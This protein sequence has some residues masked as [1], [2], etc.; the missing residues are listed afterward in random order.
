MKNLGS[1]KYKKIAKRNTL[2][3]DAPAQVP[4]DTV[5]YRDARAMTEISDDSVALVVTSPP[6]WN[7]K[8][9]SLDGTQTQRRVRKL[10]GQVGDLADYRVYLQELE[11]IWR[12]CVRVL[13]PNGKLCINAPLMPITKR[14]LNTHNSRDIVDIA[15]GIQNEIL[16]DPKLEGRLY[17]YDTIVWNRT[18]PSKG[19][20]FGSYPY[21]PNFYIQNTVEF[22]TVYVKDGPSTSRDQRTKERSRLSEQEWVEFTRQVWSLPIP[23]RGDIA[24]GE[25]PAIMPE[26]IARRLI[27]LFSFVGDVILDPFIGSGT[28]AKVALELHRHFVGY[29]IN[30]GYR[31]LIEQKVKAV[32][33]E[34]PANV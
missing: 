12:E 34:L 24:Y 19:L 21:P 16:S 18:N 26:E 15:A 32:Q 13:Q 31:P 5:F 11:K 30:E 9:Y 25:H 23:N 29:E 7:I 8:D 28:T 22:I 3:R 6:Y 27:R 14:Q 2:L 4:L 10:E 17:L 20:M 1:A 33:Y